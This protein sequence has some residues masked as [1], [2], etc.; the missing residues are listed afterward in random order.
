MVDRSWL[1]SKDT[2]PS[3]LR[4]LAEDDVPAWPYKVG[5]GDVN[6]TSITVGIH[7]GGCA[8][9]RIAYH[10]DTITR[11]APG[12]YTVERGERRG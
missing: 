2:R 6:D 5:I 7:M 3:V 12:A 4:A 9:R 1:F 10:G 8:D 11:T